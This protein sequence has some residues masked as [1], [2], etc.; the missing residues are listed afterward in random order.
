[1]VH[2]RS[3]EIRNSKKNSKYFKGTKQVMV[4]EKEEKKRKKRYIHWH[5]NMWEIPKL[6]VY[7]CNT[8]DI[9]MFEDWQ[10][11]LLSLD[12]GI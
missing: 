4:Q 3:F 1:M 2:L 10:V 8:I 6:Q 11:R 5:N 7:A 12:G 9:K